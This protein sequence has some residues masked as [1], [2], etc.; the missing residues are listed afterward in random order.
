MS[1]QEG[2]QEE[3]GE[4]RQ[5]GW[6]VEGGGGVEGGWKVEDRRTYAARGD[7]LDGG[8]TQQ[9]PLVDITSCSSRRWTEEFRMD[10]GIRGRWRG[11]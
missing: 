8:W 9:I 3:F 10:G 11:R 7:E 1:N 6:K 5:A 2:R 4:E